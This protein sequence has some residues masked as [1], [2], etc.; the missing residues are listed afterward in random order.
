M[1]DVVVA[2][3]PVKLKEG[4]K[5]KNRW[6]MLR[7]PSPVADCLI[8]VI[9]KG[10]SVENRKEWRLR[11]PERGGTLE[12]TSELLLDGIC[13]LQAGVTAEGCENVLAIVCP[14]QVIL[15][16]F[17]SHR[18]LIE[19][20]E[21]LR[22]CL[23]EVHSFAVNIPPGGRME[24]G[25][26]TLHFRHNAFA[27]TKHSPPV[28]FAHWGLSELRRYG[29][30]PGGFAFEV[31]SH[32]SSGAGVFFLSCVEA[33]QICFLF[34]CFVAGFASPLSFR[35]TPFCLSGSTSCTHPPVIAVRSSSQ[36]SSTDERSDSSQSEATAH[37]GDTCTFPHAS[38]ESG[39][40]SDKVAR[41]LDIPSSMDTLKRSTAKSEKS[42]KAS[43]HLSE[44]ARHPSTDSGITT[45]SPSIA[46]SLSSSSVSTGGSASDEAD[47]LAAKGIVGHMATLTKRPAVAMRELWYDVPRRELH[48]DCPTTCT[49]KPWAPSFGLQEGCKKKLQIRPEPEVKWS[50]SPT[51][52]TSVSEAS[53]TKKSSSPSARPREGS[54]AT[55]ALHRLMGC[56]L[57]QP[58]NQ[59][60]RISRQESMTQTRSGEGKKPTQH[61]G[62][63]SEP[64]QPVGKASTEAL[65]RC[66][67]VQLAEQRKLS[68]LPDKDSKMTEDQMREQCEEEQV[69]S[70]DALHIHEDA[71][72]DALVGT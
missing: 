71:G 17:E 3:G 26:A 61:L 35:R 21:Q 54:L 49:Y 14:L 5:W 52:I 51:E 24:P 57:L 28:S 18:R 38:D 62:C 40:E 47:V 45:A 56:S 48:K 12:P 69:L 42:R 43:Q 44:G 15:L 22:D 11:L 65:T 53:S 31:G 9:H 19:W 34:D 39:G 50:T 27:L 59:G 30:V 23:G 67:H 16:G 37:S 55:D 32:S 1:T 13:G 20:D 64:A 8:L 7:K 63:I 33:D 29:A 36:S 46:G 66:F 58:S 60:A 10:T 25:P 72:E 6:V 2:E 41:L 70:V 4:K 68:K